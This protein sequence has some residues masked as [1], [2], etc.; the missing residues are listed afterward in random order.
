MV[1]DVVAGV[2]VAQ[3]EYVQEARRPLHVLPDRS[4]YGRR[5]VGY[6]LAHQLLC[7]ICS[8][9]GAPPRPR[10]NSVAIFYLTYDK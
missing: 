8:Y 3:M 6:H 10:R 9:F 7:D 1:V 2:R 4:G 5:T